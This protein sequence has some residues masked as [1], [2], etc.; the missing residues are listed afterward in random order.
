MPELLSIRSITLEFSDLY[1]RTPIVRPDKPLARAPGVHQSDILGYVARKIGKLK[2][3]ERVEDEYPWR[4]A[5]G[6]MWEEFYFSLLPD[7]AWQPGEMTVDGI[8]VNCDGLSWVNGEAWL[9]ETKCTEKKVRAEGE[10][11]DEWMWQHQARGYCWCYGPRVVRWSVMHYRGDWR[12][13]GPIA[14]EYVVRFSDQEC[15]QT[16]AMLNQYKKAAWE[17]DGCV[18]WLLRADVPF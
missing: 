15:E 12:G 18:D 5:L 17:A 8:S 13:S 9:E 4:W 10:F 14:Q 11:L 16:W 2:P 1:R 3:G 7:A 6:Q